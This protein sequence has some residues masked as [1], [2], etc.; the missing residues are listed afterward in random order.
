[1][2]QNYPYSAWTTTP[3]GKPKQV[4]LV[5]AAYANGWEKSEHG[6]AYHTDN[7]HPTAL[8]AVRAARERVET[9]RDKL[10]TQHAAAVKKVAVLQAIEQGLSR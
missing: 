10:L 5:C 2:S 3:S 7:L 9:Q 1:M 4:V 6:K 8:A